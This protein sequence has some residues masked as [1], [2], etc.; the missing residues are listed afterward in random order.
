MLF[1]GSVLPQVL[2][3]QDQVVRERP[4]GGASRDT[5][6][7]QQTRGVPGFPRNR[8][9]RAQ[10]AAAGCAILDPTALHQQKQ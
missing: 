7:G 9:A 8:R 4:K 10:L 5:P 2:P 1:C 3:Y 6:W